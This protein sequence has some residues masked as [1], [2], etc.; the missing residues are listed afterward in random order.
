MFPSALRVISDGKAQDEYAKD[1]VDGRHVQKGDHQQGDGGDEPGPD[2]LAGSAG[3][4]DHRH[5]DQGDDDGADALEGALHPG[6]VLEGREKH[7]DGQKHEERGGDAAERGRDTAFDAAQPV[8]G[9]DGDVDG[10]DAGGALRQGHDV[11][12]VFVRN[13]APPG[14]FGLDERNHGVASADGESADFGENRKN[15]PE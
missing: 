3:H 4:L 9:E 2:L 6:I 8:A 7:G 1:D 11:G 15:L 5:G 14:H 10:H 13:P 12:Q